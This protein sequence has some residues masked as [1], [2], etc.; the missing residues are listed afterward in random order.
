MFTDR[1]LT[2]AYEKARVEE[3]DENSKYIFL[4]TSIEVME[5]YQMSSREIEIPFFMH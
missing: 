1:R 5:V 3:F 2:E 4:V